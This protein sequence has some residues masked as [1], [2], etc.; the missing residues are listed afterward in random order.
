MTP[1]ARFLDGLASAVMYGFV[2]LAAAG[3][4]AAVLSAP[5]RHTRRLPR[6]PRQPFRARVRRRCRNARLDFRARRT[7][8]RLAATW[9]TGQREAMRHL[10]GGPGE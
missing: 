9:S 3:V 6:P 5:F 8:R 1:G 4:A 10:L 2:W 7:L